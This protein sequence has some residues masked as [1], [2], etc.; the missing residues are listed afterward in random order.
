MV[1][2]GVADFNDAL[3][4]HARQLGRVVERFAIGWYAKRRWTS[5]GQVTLEESGGFVAHALPKLRGALL[6]EAA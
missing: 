1:S 5:L 4:L 6:R 3:S 2:P